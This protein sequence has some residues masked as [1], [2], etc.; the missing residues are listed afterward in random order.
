MDFLRLFDIIYFQNH[1]YP[2]KNALAGRASHGGWE[3]YST[4]DCINQ[5]NHISNELLK[6]GVTEKE[7]IALIFSHSSPMWNF[8]DW[9]ILQIGAVVV[10]IHSTSKITEI[11]YILTDAD[12]KYCIVSDAVILDKMKSQIIDFEG[13]ILCETLFN[14]EKNFDETDI[15]PRKNAI[16]AT[17]LATIM[18]TSGSTGEP[19]GVM[20]SHQNIVSNIKATL[21]TTPLHFDKMALSFLPIS[22]IFERMVV[23][24]YISAGVSVYYSSSIDNV[25]PDIKEIRPHFFTAVPRLLE[26]LYDGIQQNIQSRKK[27][28]QKI[29]QWAFSLGEKYNDQTDVGYKIQHFLADMLVFRT[30]RQALGGRV[31]GILV[32]SAALRPN[33]AKLFSAAGIQIREGYGLTE[34]SPVVST[35]RFEPGG[36]R[37]GTVGIPVSGVEVM[38]DDPN[39]LGEGEILVKG[40]NVMLGYY[41]KTEA[42]RAVLSDDG[43]FRTGDVGKFVHKRFLQITDRRKDIFKTTTGKYIAPQV[44]ETQL[45]ENPYIAQCMVVGFNR[46]HIGAL[47]VPN[48]E[49]L[50]KWCNANKVHWTSPQYMVINP[51]VVKM[52]G[53]EID[54][55]NT[56][57]TGIEKIRAFHL[58]YKVWMIESGEITPT[59][60]IKRAFIAEHFKATIEGMYKTT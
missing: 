13:F 6:I 14:T 46:P 16:V 11:D 33:I 9:G 36:V 20:L 49:A 19:K 2:K 38:I 51:K 47:I 45:L 29:I 34:T 50:E 55:L 15:L 37:F 21:T 58:L 32:G 17:D 23:Y 52:M 5:S 27:Y 24:T 42:T 39:E 48:F 40:P 26:R 22:H 10:P 8:C 7:N 31:E 25:M 43:W 30:W 28:E 35:N 12:I 18:Y 59:L 60:K 56:N 57:F 54:K 41:K 4:Q 1:R 44:I 53:E 3:S